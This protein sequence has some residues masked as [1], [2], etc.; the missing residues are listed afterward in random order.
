[1]DAAAAAREAAEE[2]AA[3]CRRVEMARSPFYR[4]GMTE[5]AFGRAR[6]EHERA[7]ASARASEELRRQESAPYLPTSPHI[8][9]YLPTC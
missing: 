2:A 5:S 7:V 6:A 8:S 3:A 4:A 1:M 9:P